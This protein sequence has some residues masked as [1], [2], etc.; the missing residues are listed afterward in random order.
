MDLD[1]IVYPTTETTSYSPFHSF[2][3]VQLKL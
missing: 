1:K 3:P 2:S